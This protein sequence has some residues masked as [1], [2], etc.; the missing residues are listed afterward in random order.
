M[1]PSQVPPLAPFKIIGTRLHTPQSLSWSPDGELAVA[2]DDSVHIYLPHFRN[3][4]LL[5]DEEDSLSD[6]DE[7]ESAREDGD[8]PFFLR[9]RI[10][11]KRQYASVPLRILIPQVTDPRVNEGLL[12]K[13]GAVVEFNEDEDDF[14]GV[15]TGVVTGFGSALNQPV[16]VQWSP[17]GLGPN[18]RP[19]VTALITKGMILAWG[20]VLNYDETASS[21]TRDFRSWKALW[22]LGGSMPLPSGGSFSVKGDRITA[23]AWAGEVADGR[24]LL[25]YHT[26]ADE[27]VVVAVQYVEEVGEGM[28]SEG[29][30]W[31][32]DEVARVAVPGPHVKTDVSF[33]VPT[34]GGGSNGVGSRPGLRALGLSVLRKVV[35][36]ALSKRH[37][38]GAHRVHCAEP[39]R[40]PARDARGLEAR[41]RAG[42]AG[43]RRGRP[44]DV[45]PPLRRGVHCVGRRGKFSPGSE[46]ALADFCRCGMRTG[47]RSAAASSPHRLWPRCS[48]L[49]SSGRPRLC[50]C[51]GRRTVRRCTLPTRTRGSPTP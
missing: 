48:R 7:S 10:S 23:F 46:G 20:E 11:G 29:P 8:R 30:A 43:Q 47:Q 35:T 12:N 26:D 22:G 38:D 37:A 40:L 39:R 49:M 13:K 36:L 2:A 15:G 51:T 3:E 24:A 21:G 27:L 9:K 28:N 4:R 19:V 31:R 33:S 44:R 18:L 45:L 41:E 17:P 34:F 1:R 6:G 42:R 50:P 16:S 32:V 14:M 5:G 25:G